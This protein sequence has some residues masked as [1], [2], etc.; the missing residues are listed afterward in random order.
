VKKFFEEFKSFIMRGNVMNLAVGV[1]IG[2]A[3]QNIVT[4]LIDNIIS[5]IIGMIMGGVGGDTSGFVGLK[6]TING[7]DLRYGAFIM[8]VI[9]FL[10]MA[11]VI[12]MLV[13]AVNAVME[14]GKKETKDEKTTKECPYC[15]STIHKDATI[16]PF[17]TSELK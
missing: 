4:S 17:C 15:K 7:T 6:L 1:I 9:N 11:F 10:I 3:F 13:K 8:S 16:C 14:L 2:A 12:F 5:P